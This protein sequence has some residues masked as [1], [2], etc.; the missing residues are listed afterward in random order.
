MG[1]HGPENYGMFRLYPRR[2]LLAASVLAVVVSACAEP[3]RSPVVAPASVSPLAE[4]VLVK[5]PTCAC[6]SEH[7][8]YL[9]DAGL[10]VRTIVD[11]QVTT[12]K[13]TNGIPTEAWSCHTSMWDG[14]F[15]EG[16]VPVA[17][18]RQ[19]IDE[20]PDIDGIALPGMPAGSPGM[21]GTL[22]GPLV[23]LAVRDGQ[24]VGEF[25]SY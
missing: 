2:A 15:I 21:G 6:C 12:L 18:I 5:S 1:C 14:Y 22:E 4:I 3:A 17:A 8:A 13:E 11:A 24:I 23:V 16:H 7:E 20:R 25:S 9:R 19:L 10:S